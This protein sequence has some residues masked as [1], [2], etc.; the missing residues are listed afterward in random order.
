VKKA[1]SHR[2][3]ALNDEH[4]RLFVNNSWVKPYRYSSSSSG[5]TIGRADRQLSA[6]RNPRPARPHTGLAAHPGQC[7][8]DAPARRRSL[9]HLRGIMYSKRGCRDTSL[10]SARRLTLLG[11]ARKFLK[12]R[13]LPASLALLCLL[14][15][16]ILLFTGII[17]PN[18]LFVSHY[19]VRGIDVSNHQKLI[20]WKSVAQTG[21]YT[22][23]FIKATE[24]KDYQ[25]AYFQANWRGTKEHGL[26]SRCIPFLC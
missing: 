9:R 4:G 14:T 5:T 8:F 12:R 15:L 21:G 2:L 3:L 6:R 10:A 11:K 26:A 23:V 24:G 16:A 25:D 7:S 20:D 1:R 22:F 18:Y 19:S 17:W 13:A